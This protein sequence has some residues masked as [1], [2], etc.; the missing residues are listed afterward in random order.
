MCDL[1]LVP[2]HRVALGFVH[3]RIQLHI[4][5]NLVEDFMV[6]GVLTRVKGLTTFDQQT[7]QPTNQLFNIHNLVE[8]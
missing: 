2:H 3:F 7:N 5:L 1:G 8:V 6:R 4:V